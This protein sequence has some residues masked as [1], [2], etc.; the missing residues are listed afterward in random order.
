VGTVSIADISWIVAHLCLYILFII[1]F[2]PVYRTECKHCVISDTIFY[3]QQQCG[4]VK[5]INVIQSLPLD[6]SNLQWL[7][8][9]IF[10]LICTHSLELNKT[11]RYC[12]NERQQQHESITDYIA[13]V[14]LKVIFFYFWNCKILGKKWKVVR[15]V[16]ARMV[17]V[18]NP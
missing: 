7:K 5:S 13:W 15:Y 17:A 8:R 14:D 3:T 1:I 18:G 10:F 6:N 2:E 12:K 11:T 4:V 16:Y 9:Y